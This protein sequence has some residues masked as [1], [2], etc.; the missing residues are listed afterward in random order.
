M[1]KDGQINQ[2]SLIFPFFYFNVNYWPPLGPEL[3]AASFG[4]GKQGQQVSDHC[5]SLSQ[6]L[7]ICINSCSKVFTFLNIR[8]WRLSWGKCLVY[9][10]KTAL[11]FKPVFILK[12]YC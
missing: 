5:G 6:K 11:P 1:K 7:F 10:K 9:F 8:G 4:R 2:I 3:R 12:P